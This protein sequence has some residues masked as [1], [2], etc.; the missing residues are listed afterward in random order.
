MNMSL[1]FTH[2]PKSALFGRRVTEFEMELPLSKSV[3]YSRTNVQIRA[4][5][6][7]ISSSQE[8]QMCLVCSETVAVTNEHETAL[9]I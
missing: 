8:N 7:T 9:F 1:L 3:A 4:A 5:Q 6:I 2:R